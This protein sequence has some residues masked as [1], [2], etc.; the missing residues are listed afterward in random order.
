MFS[1]YIGRCTV[2]HMHESMK[3]DASSRTHIIQLQ[4]S[5][6]TYS[7]LL[8]PGWCA[9]YASPK[10]LPS[11]FRRWRINASRRLNVFLHPPIIV[12]PANSICGPSAGTPYSA[13]WPSGTPQ[14]THSAPRTG[15]VWVRMWRLRSGP[16]RLCWT[17]GQYGQRQREDVKPGR[18]GDSDDEEGAGASA[19]TGA[20]TG[21]LRRVQVISSEDVWGCGSGE[22][23]G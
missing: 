12:I 5:S 13:A 22:R 4:S 20:D 16:R 19:D 15:R 14:Q 9:A 3:P 6:H 18:E 2:L 7:A 8:F 11:S 10:H 23:D 1:D 21:M 17:Y